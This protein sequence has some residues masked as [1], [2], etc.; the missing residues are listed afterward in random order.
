MRSKPPQ[1][2]KDFSPMSQDIAALALADRRGALQAGRRWRLGRLHRQ[3]PTRNGP[4]FPVRLMASLRK[5]M[6]ELS[7]VYSRSQQTHEQGLPAIAGLDVTAARGLADPILPRYDSDC[8]VAY[9]RERNRSR[10]HGRTDRS[11][12]YRAVDRHHTRR[13]SR[14]TNVADG[15]PMGIHDVDVPGSAQPHRTIA[16]AGLKGA[17]PQ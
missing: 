8:H 4:R 7:G 2:L 16:I 5:A 13:G 15:W 11:T 6:S 10:L 1:G 14:F 12:V 3:E 17:E 9:A